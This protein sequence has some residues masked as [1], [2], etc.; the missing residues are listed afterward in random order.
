MFSI[1]HYPNTYQRQYLPTF[2]ALKKIP[3]KKNPQQNKLLLQLLVS[4][5]LLVCLCNYVIAFFLSIFCRDARFLLRFAKP[6]GK[7]F[8]HAKRNACR[9]DFGPTKYK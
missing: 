6:L 8:A 1:S 2:A 3:F 5:F 4:F 9:L 7:F